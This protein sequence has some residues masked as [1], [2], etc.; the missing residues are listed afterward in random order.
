MHACP[1]AQA[2]HEVLKNPWLIRLVQDYAHHLDPLGYERSLAGIELCALYEPVYGTIVEFGVRERAHKLR[3]AGCAYFMVHVHQRRTR[4]MI[5]HQISGSIRLSIDIFGPDGQDTTEWATAADYNWPAQEA[6]RQ[7]LDIFSKC[8]RALVTERPNFA[9]LANWVAQRMREERVRNGLWSYLHGTEVILVPRVV[10]RALVPF[11][12]PLEYDA[13]GNASL[14]PLTSALTF[15][16]TKNK[17]RATIRRR[18]A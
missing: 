8:L 6:E 17:I 11:A 5:L 16:C 15:C 14:L 4:V 18:Q 7:V 12:G 2:L 1:C 10:V 13:D 9:P 3:V